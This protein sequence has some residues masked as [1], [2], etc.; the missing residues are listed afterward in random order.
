MRRNLIPTVGAGL[1]TLLACT[2]PPAATPVV[3]TAHQRAVLADSVR[4]VADSVFAAGDRRDLDRM[5]SYYSANTTLLQDGKPDPW[6]LHQANAR[7]FYATLQDAE[8]KPLE[9]SVD[10]IS[11][12]A[13]IWHGTYWYKLTDKAGKVIQGSAASTWVFSRESAGWRIV[14]VH[15]SDPPPPPN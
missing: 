5:F 7:A 9:Y 14:H 13:A 2:S 15:I 8:V 1:L 4:A 12:T 11:P 6:P 3:M 10:V